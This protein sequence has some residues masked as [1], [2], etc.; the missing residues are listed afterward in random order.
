MEFQVRF[1]F[2][3]REIDTDLAA[4][5]RRINYPFALMLLALILPG[6]MIYVI[7]SYM[8]TAMHERFAPDIA[9]RPLVYVAHMPDSL[10]GP[11]M[12]DWAWAALLP[13][14]TSVTPDVEAAKEKVANKEADLCVVFPPDFDVAVEG[15][16]VASM[17]PAPNI[18]IYYHSAEI[19]AQNAFRTVTAMLDAYEYTL[20]NK[21]DINRGIA[22]DLASEED[23]S[24]SMMS[25]MMPMLLITLLYSG[26]ISIAPESIA[27]EKERGTIGALLVSP[28]KRSQLAIGKILS[29]GALSLLPGLVSTVATI[30][31]LSKMMSVADEI[32][33]NIYGLADYIFL[34]LTIFST[35]LLLVA[36]ISVLSAFAK[37]VKEAQTTVVP[38]MIVVMVVG[39]SGMFGDGAQTE[40][41][42]YLVPI[43]NSVQCMSALFSLAYAPLHMVISAISNL[44]YAFL[45]GFILTKMFNSEK[46]MFA[47]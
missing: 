27:G 46:I 31:S 47:R 7:Y 9:Y 17:A 8:G 10:R 40:G 37:T 1:F 35:V 16:E 26:C 38:L 13:I 11:A 2:V 22:A 12:A 29:L 14:G 42:Y 24:A 15:Y 21:F 3:C 39:V 6:V 25:M 33:V 41:I 36:L 43:Y 20:A 4:V 28:L 19:N 18:E 23:I 30:L 5:F 44:A 45:C 34:A 32:R